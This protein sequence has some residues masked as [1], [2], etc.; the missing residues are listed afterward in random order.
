MKI[1]VKGKGQ[2][3]ITQRDF[4]A[5]GG[6]ASV[7]KKGDVCYKIYTDPKNCIPEAKIKEL[8]V[9]QIK[10]IVRPED[11]ILDN[12]NRPLGYT[13][14]W[15][16][17]GEALCKLFTKTYRMTNGLT[18]DQIALLTRHLQ[19]I[20][21]YTHSKGIVVVD[22][23]EL[24]YLVVKHKE[25][26]AIDVNS[27]QTPSFPA[28]VIMP[29]IRD[30]HTQGFNANSDWFSFA[31]LS[32]NMMVGIHPYKGGH[33]DFVNIPVGERMEARMKANVSAFHPKA[34][35]PKVC[36]ALDVIP[37]GLKSW[38]RAI[39]EEGK[40][41]PPPND[42]QTAAVVIQVKEIAGSNLFEI[43]MIE[44]YHHYIL[45]CY[46][47][48]PLR[49]VV[50]DKGIFLNKEFKPNNW[51]MRV[52]FSPKMGWPAGIYL[53][54]DTIHVVDLRNMQETEL[55][56]AKE[57]FEYDGRLYAVAGNDVLE[58]TLTEIGNK[59]LPAV[60]VVSRVLDVPDATKVYQGVIVQRVLDRYV[61]SIFPQSG[62]CRQ[63]NLE[64]L[65]DYRVLDGKYENNVLMLMAEKGG[66]YTRFVMRFSPDFGSHD[67]RIVE[68]VDYSDLNFTVTDAGIC[69]MINEE[70]KIEAFS[71]KK[72][73]GSVKV[74]EDPAIDGTMRLFHDGA[75]VLF[76]KEGKLYSITMRKK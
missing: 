23:N 6:E 16:D 18:H 66:K 4:V 44:D 48:G 61:V 58:I 25:I 28:T 9:L 13:S 60:K 31:V 2:I 40:R 57:V 59:I 1:F 72:D 73:A 74:M 37:A 3:E 11:I 15:V 63:I 51:K 43:T 55:G 8:S 5:K 47:S 20:V 62:Q 33:P 64:E 67:M 54:H 35:L 71:N 50:T 45:G 32:F 56:H 52:G 34:T 65:D 39:L 21:E 46:H 49:V 22:L 7:Y 76:A 69:T 38:L 12:K 14:Q 36:E 17:H 41:L 27:Y 19:N 26:Y 75:K 68:D 53:A 42:Y 30:W 29:N 24:N 70:E 10:N